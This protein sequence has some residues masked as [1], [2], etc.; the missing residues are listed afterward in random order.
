[1]AASS[2]LSGAVDVARQYP[3]AAAL[4]LMAIA[5]EAFTETLQLSAAVSGLVVTLAAVMVVVLMRDVRPGTD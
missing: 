2:T 3:G 4:Q 5:R 1:M